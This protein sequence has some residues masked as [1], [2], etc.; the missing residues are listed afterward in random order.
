MR[1]QHF[2]HAELVRASLLLVFICCPEESW[3]DMAYEALSLC[4]LL[5]SAALASGG[6]GEGAFHPSERGCAAARELYHTA[7]DAVDGARDPV[8]Q[9]L[10]NGEFTE[11]TIARLVREKL[12]FLL[13][14]VA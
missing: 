1:P 12:H 5:C 2:A 14:P 3:K 13:S 7:L 6:S 8:Y 4:F 11:S 10:Q 9:Y